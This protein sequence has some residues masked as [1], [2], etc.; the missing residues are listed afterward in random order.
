MGKKCS[1]AYADIYM[2]TCEETILP[3]CQK[4]PLSYFRYL[5]DIWGTWPHSAAEFQAFLNTLNTHHTSIKVK[6]V[7]NLK[8]MDFLDVTTYKGVNFNTTGKL[9]TKVSFKPTDSHA[10]LHRSSFQPRHTFQGIIKS[11]LIRFKRICSQTTDYNAAVAILFTALKRRGYNRSTLRRIQQNTQNKLG[12]PN[13]RTGSNANMAIIPFVTT[14]SSLAMRT[15]KKAKN[16]FEEILE[17]T[18]VKQAIKIIWA[19]KRNPNLKDILVHAKMPGFNT[20]KYHPNTTARN[21]TSKQTLTQKFLTLKH[22]NCVYLIRCN[23]CRKTLYVGETRNTLATRLAHHRYNIRH[24]HKTS[25]H[26]VKHFIEHGVRNL[27]LQGIQQNHRWST[28]ER[29]KAE[30]FWIRKLGTLHP[31]GLNID[32]R[33]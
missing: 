8:E 33:K 22:S 21:H 31:K 10:L 20:K 2:A 23:V 13:R 29:R 30:R 28:E 18:P 14:F 25:T 32:Y 24:K 5:D 4:R 27:H 1:P 16:N 17:H 9:D 12:P 19:Y 6:A 15:T 3:K 26:L 11:Q 7:T